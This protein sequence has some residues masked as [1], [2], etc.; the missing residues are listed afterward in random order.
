MA[1]SYQ[2]TERQALNGK[3]VSAD[4]KDQSSKR[5]V[6]RISQQVNHQTLQSANHQAVKSKEEVLQSIRDLPSETVRNVSVIVE[7]VYTKSSDYSKASVASLR[8]IR[9]QIKDVIKYYKKWHA[10]PDHPSIPELSQSAYDGFVG[11]AKVYDELNPTVK[12]WC[13]RFGLHEQNK[14]AII[15]GSHQHS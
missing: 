10:D 14:D 15:R 12:G 4:A 6:L 3:S 7:H 11:I 5:P 8:K 13:H 1:E 9:L 2:P